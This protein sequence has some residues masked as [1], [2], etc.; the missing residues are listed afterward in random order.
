MA[1]NGIKKEFRLLLG[2]GIVAAVVLII[3]QNFLSKV[4]AARVD[5]GVCVQSSDVLECYDH[6]DTLSGEE[7]T[8]IAVSANGQMLATSSHQ[9]IRLWD[10]ST[11][12][13]LYSWKGHS[14]WVTA[15]A[16]SPDSQMLASSSLDQ[17]IK[18]WNLKTGILLGTI[19]AGR[20]TCLEF[21]L[22]GKMLAG[23]SRIGRWVD[24]KTSPGGVQLWNVATQGLIGN[25]GTGPVAALNFSP[26]GRL[27]A[28]GSKN[29]QIWQIATRQRIR[30]L[31]SG[32]IT[33]LAF[34]RDSQLL[35][36]GSSRIKI[37]HVRSGKLLHMLYSSASDLALS[38]DGKTLAAANG[39]TINFWQ[40]GT[41]KFLGT[42]R[43]SWY[44]G[45]FV[46]FDRDSQSMITGSSDG[47]KIWQPRRIDA[48]EN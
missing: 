45:L 47:I 40:L 4:I 24:E 23:G 38:P 35:I 8:A 25:M 27:L 32:D 20:V 2:I 15:L 19:P 39:G 14:N 3:A 29:T 16:I 44:S 1:A 10:L 21:S 11:S 9:M 31:N 5:R 12:K 48:L 6:P 30:T 42:L 7:T 13:L 43:G 37:W 22:D 28:M 46:D 17:T 36:S 26:N 34:S 18:L 41:R 33:A